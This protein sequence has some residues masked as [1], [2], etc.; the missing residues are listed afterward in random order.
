MA[1]SN[2]TV[3][4]F[5]NVSFKFDNGRIILDEV[6]FSIR[7]GSKITIMGQNGAGKSTIFK[8]ITG[9][10]K[11]KYGV[12]NVDKN[13]SIATAFQ[14]MPQADRDLDLRAYFRKYAND[15][16]Y[17]IDVKINEAL[18]TVNLKAPLDRI[19][20]SFSGGQQARLLLAAALIGNPDILLLDE[21]TNNLDAAGIDHLTEFLVNY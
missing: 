2:E 10:L 19:V 12:I 16:S 7:K 20:R 5:N 18:A 6:D 21:P 14:S 8:M 11:N 9:E 15:D 1:P 17:N 4:R 3:V 13:L